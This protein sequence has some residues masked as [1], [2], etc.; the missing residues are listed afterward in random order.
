MGNFAW[1]F[2]KIGTSHGQS[3]TWGAD[4]YAANFKAIELPPRHL[5]LP[6]CI[7][8]EV[9]R[10]DME[11]PPFRCVVAT[12]RSAALGSGLLGKPLA[13]PELNRRLTLSGLGKVF[14]FRVVFVDLPG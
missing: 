1:H 6:Y 7:Y 10:Y 2:V 12:D 4:L 14:F 3:P 9:Y 5:S 11:D 8:H 13:A